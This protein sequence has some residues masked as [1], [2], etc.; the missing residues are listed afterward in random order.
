MSDD[1]Q[2]ATR[3]PDI[4]EFSSTEVTNPSLGS[5]ASLRL[6][7]RRTPTLRWDPLSQWANAVDFGAD[8]T[9]ER[10]SSE[11]IQ[12]AI[13]SGASTVFL[14]GFMAVQ[15]TVLV[16]S[17]VQ[18]IIG[19]GGWVDYNS[20]CKPDFRIVDGASAVVQIEH[21][22]SINGGIE[23]DTKRTIVLKSLGARSVR[24][25]DRSK[26][27]EVFFEDVTTD[28]LR[29]HR[30]KMWARQLNIE[31][32]G[33]HLTNDASD[34]WIL[35][36]KTERGGTLLQT[37][38]GGRSEVLGGFSYTTTAGKLAP[39]FVTRD[40]SVFAYFGEIC[41]SG[42]PY[43]DLID[44]TQGGKR[45]KLEREKGDTLPYVSRP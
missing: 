19:T 4:R 23:I 7:A 6:P 12:R 24:F 20:Q 1:E 28:D 10:D 17:N 43:V 15:R 5:Q 9:G 31:N 3:G 42:D 35:G 13:D 16:R 18:R 26:K 37:Q 36:Y 22:S 40:S 25:T 41:Y 11:A 38:N 21:F 14:P 27:S 2:P 44:E 33:T 32:E 39:M 8:P 34:V 45:N 30:Q 29:L